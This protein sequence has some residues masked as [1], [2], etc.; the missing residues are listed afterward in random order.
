[1]APP[2]ESNDL[3]RQ[4]AE[5]ARATAEL[6]VLQR[7]SSEINSTLDLEEIY[8]IALR[9]M[10]ELFEFHHAIIL[11]LE[12]DGETLT[13]VA[14][15]GYEN[16]AVGGHVRIGTGVI[17]IVAQRRKMLHVANLGHQRAYAAA[18]RR[19]MMKS[20][21]RAELGEAV[22][23]PGLPNAESQ[24]A[25]PLLMRD[26][27]I[28]VFS[29]ESPVRYGFSEHDR[30]L[31]LIV[32]NQIASAV[33]KA[34]LYEERRRAAEALQ[35]ANASL[36]QRVAER[37]AAL[38][39][40]LRVAQELLSAARSRVEGPLLG[41]SPEVR[42]LRDA[43]ARE[44][45]RS[46]P[47]LLSGPTGAG[48]E[49]V[50]HAL[51][52]ASGRR[53]AFIFINC[54]ELQTES[55]KTPLEPMAAR[56]EQ[57]L[58]A[59]KVELASGG[60]L[61][62]E[63]F[64]ELAPGL[65]AELHALIEAREQPEAR[66]PTGLP[67]GSL[68][69]DMRVIVATIRDPESFARDGRLL[70]LAARLVRNVI[71]VPALVD[72]REDIPALVE[73]FI[74]RHARRLGKI[75]N[76]VSSESM[77]RLQAYKWPGNIRELSTV[78]ERALL[79]SRGTVLEVD[80]DLLDERLA[81]G[82]Y[83]LVSQLGSGGMGEV[84]LA[85]HRLLA[86]PAAVK[87][88]R[89]D[90][91]QRDA[92]AQLVRRFQREALVTAGLRSPHTVQLYDFGVNDTGS[93]YYVMEFLQGLDLHR[94][95]TRFGPQPAE[96]V[97]MLLCQACRSL[98]EAHDR[99][100]VHRDIKPANLFVTRLGHEY[101]YLKVLDFGIVKDQPRED[102][103]LI[104]AQGILQGTPAFIAPEV[105][106]GASTLDGRA[107]L[108][109]LACT[110]YWMLTGQLVFGASTPAEM[111]LHHARTVPIPPSHVSE[112][113]IPGELDNLLMRCLEKDPSS[114][115]S[116]ALELE[117]ELSRVALDQPWT[118]E[119]AREWWDRHAPDTLREVQI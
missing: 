34:R 77:A 15:R 2:R 100:L 83:R 52:R 104:S 42:A 45:L 36:E 48:K 7:V 58:L 31:V 114:R 37:T 54:A 78:V 117:S 116:S 20:D 17:G 72:R 6:Q 39:R 119:K 35:V 81:V 97:T 12:P 57:R 65:Q 85:K 41:D 68:P 111:I 112:L 95:V 82:S 47:L 80:E 62:L 115:P 19:Q 59:S 30:G 21:R 25:I 24:F 106:F 93:F 11:L 102:A 27:L 38:E 94:I 66:E 43:V 101:D 40:E 118:Q 86:R 98:A 61:F 110:A 22:P 87:L 8:E 113:P 23:V 76:R 44:A 9:T 1:V 109:S 89:H 16:Q 69:H 26:E 10:D 28:G 107:D 50:A 53:G 75:V 64:H 73:H 60:T 88:I 71:R 74:R 55:R 13:V 108:Y 63:A 79:V 49:A 29:I 99:G 103:T 14:S 46:E 92:H 33:H 56:S 105:M 32:A 67:T 70:P 91:Q 4:A 84:W 5:L 90:P 51:H 18:Q 96:R 3:A